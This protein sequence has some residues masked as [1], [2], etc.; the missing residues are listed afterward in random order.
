MLAHS[1]CNICYAKSRKPCRTWPSFYTSCFDWRNKNSTQIFKSFDIVNWNTIYTN[2]YNTINLSFDIALLPESSEVHVHTS[3]HSFI[4]EIY[5][6]IYL[7]LWYKGRPFKIY[8]CLLCYLFP[9]C[10]GLI[11]LLALCYSFSG[12]RC[13]YVEATSVLF[14]RGVTTVLACKLR[15]ERMQAIANEVSKGEYDIVIL[16]EV[17]LILCLLKLNW[18]LIEYI[19]IL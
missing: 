13:I 16:Q 7:H 10:V 11:T 12:C 9:T 18:I 6:A 17:G 19:L 1:I 4:T 8:L 3:I 5:I 2:Q 14:T 15:S